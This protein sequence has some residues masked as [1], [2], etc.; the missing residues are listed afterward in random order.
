[1]GEDK[2][3][4]WEEW[5]KGWEK[6]KDSYKEGQG[7]IF[8]RIRERHNLQKRLEQVLQE[9]IEHLSE[10]ISEAVYLHKKSAS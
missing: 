8:R 2:V 3:K 5:K 10:K 4:G 6:N 1:M 9:E 7:K